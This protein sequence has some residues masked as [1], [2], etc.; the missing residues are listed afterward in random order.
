[1]IL[2][3]RSTHE[4]SKIRRRVTN[5]AKDLTKFYFLFSIDDFLFFVR[6][7]QIISLNFLRMHRS[8][9]A[10]SAFRH[11]YD[12]STSIILIK[13]HFSKKIRFKT[14]L[15]LSRFLCSIVF[16]SRISRRVHD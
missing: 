9:F 16:D 11:C 7:S 10:F 1:M 15:R 8:S 5:D 14:L 12:F 2:R 6:D 13:F 3:L 4:T